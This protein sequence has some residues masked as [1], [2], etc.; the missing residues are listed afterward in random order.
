MTQ[1]RKHK[2]ETINIVSQSN[3]NITL[4]YK[5]KR[6]WYVKFW[7]PLIHIYFLAL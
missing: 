7:F 4:I 6:L 3:K 5:K 1:Q 2:L